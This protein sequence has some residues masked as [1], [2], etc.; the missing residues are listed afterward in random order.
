[1]NEI[2]ISSLD[3]VRIQSRIDKARNGGI[4]APINLVPLMN[5]LNRA[6]KV[7]PAKVPKDLVTMNSIITLQ[8][9]KTEQITKLQ[10]VYPEDADL[11]KKKISIFAPIGTALLGYR[12]GDI[13]SWTIPS[14]TAEF[15]ILDIVYQP[16]S[17]G[18][19]DL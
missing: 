3:A 17:E 7:E 6:K 10:I 13:I 8:N 18:N 19:F 12:K 2:L 15:K 14:G 4:N 1:M 11:T 5:E 16:E 9:I